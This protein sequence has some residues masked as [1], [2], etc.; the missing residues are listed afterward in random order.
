MYK[1]LFGTDLVT[2]D[3]LNL[4]S[5]FVL[6]IYNLANVKEKKHLLSH[7]SLWA[8]NKIE[9]SRLKNKFLSSYIPWAITEIILI[10][11][12]RFTPIL[13]SSVVCSPSRTPIEPT[14]S[15]SLSTKTF[16]SILSNKGAE[17]FFQYC[18]TDFEL[19]K[20]NLFLEP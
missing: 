5:F 2:Y 19:H 13:I 12:A 7:A 14:S 3:I 16:K 15:L 17:N 20:H 11:T 1:N 4:V 6:V 10:S 8:Q 18:S 9:N